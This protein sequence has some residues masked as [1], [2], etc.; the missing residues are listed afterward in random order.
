MAV[1]EIPGILAERDEA[2]GWRKY[3]DREDAERQYQ[4]IVSLLHRP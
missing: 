2:L 4:R 1:E 3:T